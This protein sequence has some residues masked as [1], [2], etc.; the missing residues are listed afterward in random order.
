MGHVG[1]VDPDS[2]GRLCGKRT[3]GRR[4]QRSIAQAPSVARNVDADIAQPSVSKSSFQL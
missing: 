1:G 2:G 4:Q 3:V